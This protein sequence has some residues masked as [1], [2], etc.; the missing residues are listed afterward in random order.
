VRRFLKIAGWVSCTAFLIVVLLAV[1]LFV[2]WGDPVRTDRIVLQETSP[3]GKLVAE[4]HTR[5]TAMWGGPDTLYVSIRRMKEA[6][7]S[8][9]Y[10]QV[11]ECD[12]VSSFNLKWQTP[13]ELQLETGKCDSSPA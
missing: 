4:L 10:E 11:Y 12:D 1:A 5:I 7:S 6:S 13:S 2:S 9:V 8:K 3:D